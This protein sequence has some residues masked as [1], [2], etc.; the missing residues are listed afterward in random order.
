MQVARELRRGSRLT[1]ALQPDQHDHGRR[2]RGKRD[3]RRRAAEQLGQLLVDDL[4]HLLAG[5]ELA[6][7][8][9]ADATLADRGCELLDD[10]QVDVS[11]EQREADLAHRLRHV[12]LA[13]RAAA[14]QRAKRRLEL[15]RKCLEHCSARVEE[16]GGRRRRAPGRERCARRHWSIDFEGFEFLASASPIPA[17]A[18]VNSDGITKTL[19]ASPCASAGSICRYW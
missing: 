11:L 12:L 13:Q 17:N 16:I 19:L 1:G 10:V 9:G 18:C 4:Q 2:A 14:A 6:H 5:V 15:L 3:R 7:D 8:L